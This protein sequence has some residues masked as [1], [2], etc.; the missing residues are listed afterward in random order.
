[1]KAFAMTVVIVLG[2][3]ALTPFLAGFKGKKGVL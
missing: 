1:M 3:L 2:A